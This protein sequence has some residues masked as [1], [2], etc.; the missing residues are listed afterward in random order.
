MCVAALALEGQA[1]L[2]WLILTYS[3]HAI[4]LC[5]PHCCLLL[6]VPLSS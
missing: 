2:V 1:A 5:L 6:L 4:H 3:L